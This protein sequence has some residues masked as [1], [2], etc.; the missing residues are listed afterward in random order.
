[1]PVGRGRSETVLPRVRLQVC[2]ALPPFPTSPR[3]GNLGNRPLLSLAIEKV[4]VHGR[5]EDVTLHVDPKLLLQGKS[6]VVVVVEDLRDLLV[7]EKGYQDIPR[8]LGIDG[9]K[10]KSWRWD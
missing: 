5:V 2:V 9:D 6:V 8:G 7:L 4:G 3:L 10:R 1:M